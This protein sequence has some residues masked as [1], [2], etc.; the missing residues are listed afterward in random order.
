L[1]HIGQSPCQQ[2]GVSCIK[3]LRRSPS[4]YELNIGGIFPAIL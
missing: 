1:W 4:F 3:R 2:I